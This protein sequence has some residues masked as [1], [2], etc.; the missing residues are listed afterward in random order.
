MIKKIPRLAAGN[1]A[2]ILGVALAVPFAVNAQTFGHDE[3]VESKESRADARK[4]VATE[5]FSSKDREVPRPMSGH[6]Q[7]KSDAGSGAP[8]YVDPE[9]IHVLQKEASRR[10]SAHVQRRGELRVVDVSVSIDMSTKIILADVK[11][12]YRPEP[13]GD[14]MFLQE[15]A[16]TLR[17]YAE[18][19]GLPINDVDIQF[20]GHPLKYYYPEELKVPPRVSSNPENR[21]AMVSAGHGLVRV[22]PALNWDYQRPDAFGF[23]EDMI[24]PAYGDALQRLLEERSTMTIHRARSRSMELHPDSNRPWEQMSSRYHI[25]AL[26]PERGDLWN[27]LP[28]LVSN[29]REVKEDIRVRPLYANHLGAGTMISLHTNGNDSSSVRGVEVYYHVDKPQDR[30]LATSVL[31]GMRELIRAQPGYEDFPVREGANAGNHGEN[32]IGTMPSVLVEIA[33]HSNPEDSVA[34]QDPVF[35]TASMKGVEKGVRLFR[36]EKACTPLFLS[37]IDNITLPP[38][39]SGATAV[40]FEGNPQFPLTVT[41]LPAWCSEPGACTPYEYVVTEPSASPVRLKLSCEGSGTG[42]AKWKTV[43]RDADGVTTGSV[44]HTQTCALPSAAAKG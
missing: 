36:E 35:R 6:P 10:V 14:E 28:N 24:T 20:Q 7:P 2:L 11:D 4:N 22:H 15:L 8:W 9:L 13:D 34:L 33:Y 18:K 1:R 31:C 39:S 44:E 42:T 19:A 23:R 41:L 12:G 26:L 30:A 25:K 43:M 29:D 3:F 32:R 17:H 21:T 5:S 40:H 37:S 38:L 27:S 16:V